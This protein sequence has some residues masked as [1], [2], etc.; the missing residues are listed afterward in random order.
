M[1]N[2]ADLEMFVYPS[3]RHFQ[4]KHSV[5]LYPEAVEGAPAG[6]IEMEA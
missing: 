4:L 5:L 3:I 1:T 2:V 6:Y